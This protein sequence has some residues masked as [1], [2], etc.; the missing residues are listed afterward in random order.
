MLASIASG[1]SRVTGFASSADCQATL[2]CIRKLG[3]E[4]EDD[5]L[6]SGDSRRGTVRLPSRSSPSFDS[7]PGT[8]A[9]R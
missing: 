8:Q 4:V 6:R 9:R 7:T 2:D 1:P 3:I 5:G